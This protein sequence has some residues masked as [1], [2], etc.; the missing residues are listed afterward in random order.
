L[1][2]FNTITKH[3]FIF[4]N[5]LKSNSSFISFN[6]NLDLHKNNRITRKMSA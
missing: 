5:T 2:I 4:F 6:L 3:N 1:K